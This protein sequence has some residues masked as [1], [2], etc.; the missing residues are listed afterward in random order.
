MRGPL[1]HET[2]RCWG[3]G[4]DEAGGRRT[5]VPPQPFVGRTSMSGSLSS[6]HSFRGGFEAELGIAR[7]SFRRSHGYVAI[8]REPCH[9]HRA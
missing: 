9:H 8:C 2:V 5:S 4:V 7:K 6:T 3:S 1:L